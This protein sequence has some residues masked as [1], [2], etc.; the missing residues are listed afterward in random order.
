MPRGAGG[1]QTVPFLTL[2]QEMNQT[3]DAA[4]RASLKR[5]LA[6]DTVG[7]VRGEARA[8]LRYRRA[9]FR[10]E[11]L[12]PPVRVR[13]SANYRVNEVVYLLTCEALENALERRGDAA[14]EAGG[15]CVALAQLMQGQPDFEHHLLTQSARNNGLA[16]IHRTLALTTA[17]EAA[18]ARLQKSLSV[19]RDTSAIASVFRGERW[20]AHELSQGITSGSLDVKEYLVPPAPMGWWDGEWL[21]WY[22]RWNQRNQ[23]RRDHTNLL[24]WHTR[25]IE[26]T[27]LPLSKQFA[28]EEQL[29]QDLQRRAGPLSQSLLSSLLLLHSSERQQVCA[30][31]AMHA[32]LGVERYRLR[33]GKWPAKLD[34]CVPAFLDKVP[35]DPIDEAPL[36]YKILPEGVVVYSLG[37]NRTDDGGGVATHREDVGYRLW[38][39]QQRGIAPPPVPPPPPDLDPE[40]IP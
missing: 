1:P 20:F 36:R 4:H 10:F 25:M 31:T 38:D 3:L 32:L 18:L 39:T 19:P 12:E 5:F 8:L 17:S 6:L 15:A 16:S 26:I 24:R 2:P 30:T 33:H 11:L 37:N 29:Q 28:A 13:P 23:V 14:L 7:L 34:D 35:L 22:H 27:A 40:N 9:H 21:A